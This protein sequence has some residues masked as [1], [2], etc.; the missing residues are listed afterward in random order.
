MKSKNFE[1]IAI[2]ENI[3]K[4]PHKEHST[5]IYLT[6]SYQF[7]SAEEMRDLFTGDIEGNIYSRYSN[8]N[9]NELIEKIAGLEKMENAW[10]TS[11]GMAAV[12]TTFM[13][14]LKNGDHIL[15]S[16]SV[17][18]STHQLFFNIFP[19]YGITT[20]YASI[21]NL[22]D[23]EKL[24][25][26]NTKIIYAETPSNPALDLI[27]LEV[28]G[29][30][31]KKHNLILIIDNCFTTPYLQTPV[32]FGCDISIHSATKYIDGQGRGL[33]GL[34]VG[35][36]EL[37]AKIEAFARHSGPA[38]SPF[39]AWMFSKSLETLAVRMD[40]HCDNALE[41]A[42]FLEKSEFVEKVK[43]PFLPSHPQFEIAKK[44]MKKGGGMVTFYF[45]GSLEKGVKFINSLKMCS[46]S[47]NLG[48]T[49]TIVTHPASS[50]HSKLTEEERNSVDI[51]YN[52]IR[53]SVGLESIDDIKED[54]NQA[55][56]VAFA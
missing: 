7:D 11:S 43:Y 29:K 8:P 1:T 6:S 34:I 19:N 2:R 48:D 51:T 53:I 54:I 18:G 52:L 37:I 26:P 13:A 36:N 42:E 30:L 45:K 44:Q 27:D 21:H 16:S 4:S 31:A 20:S 9:T 15:S 50:T 46:I 33:G 47:A 32:D 23:W 12:F 14:L 24:I 39:N 28:L 3:E 10:C 22:D 41:I 38:L 5:P 35:S 55:L 40:R 56:N 49:K 25:Q 17:F